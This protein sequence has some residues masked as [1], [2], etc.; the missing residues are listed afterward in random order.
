MTI[1]LPISITALAV[2]VLLD[3]ISSIGRR[4]ACLSDNNT[5]ASEVSK[6]P[7]AGQC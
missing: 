3:I 2:F 4:S 6:A 7:K 5:H 1:L